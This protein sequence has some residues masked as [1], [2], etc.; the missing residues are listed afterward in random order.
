MKARLESEDGQD[1]LALWVVVTGSGGHQEDVN[2][3]EVLVG[4]RRLG[5]R[6]GM[7]GI[8]DQKTVTQATKDWFDRRLQI[9]MGFGENAVY[10]RARE[11]MLTVQPNL[12]SL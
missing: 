7:T 11:W 12:I 2:G 9:A 8:N 6:L 3:P 4:L 5:E 10:R 1:R